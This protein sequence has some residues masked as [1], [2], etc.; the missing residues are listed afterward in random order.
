M[1][2]SSFEDTLRAMKP[3]QPS[4]ELI[5]R[6]ERDLALAAMFR[7]AGP[8]PAVITKPSPWYA[9]ATWS[10]LGAAAAVLVMSA[11]PPAVV[12]STD[13]VA[14]TSANP[15]V[16]PVNSSRDLVQVEEGGIT[17]AKPDSPER[18]LRVH[19]VE[20]HQ[21]VDPRTGAEYTVEVPVTSSVTMPVKFQ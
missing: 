14:Q 7:D 6:V 5:N 17:F 15:E 13:G 16:L 4:D 21:W 18:Q 2:D 10:L 8:A 9:P 11:L 12:P 3:V 1:N 19:A 20:R